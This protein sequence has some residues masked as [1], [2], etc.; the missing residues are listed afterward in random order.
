MKMSYSQV[1]PSTTT[2]DRCDCFLRMVKVSGGMYG[3]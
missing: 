3:C 1:S 2:L